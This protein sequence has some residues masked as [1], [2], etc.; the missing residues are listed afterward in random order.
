[1]LRGVLHVCWDID[2]LVGSGGQ[3]WANVKEFCLQKKA[4]AA[5]NIHCFAL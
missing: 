3:T 2:V 1:M 4:P 5:S